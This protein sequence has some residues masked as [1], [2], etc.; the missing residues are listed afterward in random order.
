MTFA[1]KVI[2]FNRNLEYTGPA[3]PEGIRIMNPFKEFAQTM[4]IADAFYHKYYNDYNTRHLILGI[5]PGRF[6]G[7]LTG[8]PFTD[9]KRLVSECHIDYKGK[10]THEPSS[11]FVYD[12]INA[13]GGPEAF[14]KKFYIN[15]LFPLGF[16]KVEANGKEKNYNYYDSKELSKAVT[17]PIVDNI[18][19]QI[20]LDVKTDVCFC[21]GTGKNEQF[22]SRIN[23]ENHF[24]KKIVA[25][26]HPRFIMQYKTLSKQ[27]YIHKYLE[28]FNNCE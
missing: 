5:N 25:L 16:T 19:K 12:M 14:Y 11:V 28:A 26:E 3:L 15:S 22:L 20:A 24:F 27:F 21:F 9:P 4:Q 6:G 18:R 13:F 23:Q 10:P 2:L 1:D 8:I 7:G 17:E